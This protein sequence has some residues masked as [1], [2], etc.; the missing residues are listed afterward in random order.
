[1][2]ERW[3][4]RDFVIYCWINSRLC[5]RLIGFTPDLTHGQTPPVW[6]S[7][8]S[9]PFGGKPATEDGFVY[10]RVIWLSSIA[11]GSGGHGDLMYDRYSFSQRQPVKSA[12]I[13]VGR[14]KFD[15]KSLHN[16]FISATDRFE[17][18]ARRF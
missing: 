2:K 14:T 11:N 12:N 8:F 7:C 10:I 6:H 17:G 9:P 5:A 15:G 18:R 16:S 3:P 13:T 1:M 4:K